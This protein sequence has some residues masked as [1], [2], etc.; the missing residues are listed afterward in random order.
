M[1]CQ[2]LHTRLQSFS[3]EP[4]GRSPINSTRTA[5]QTECESVHRQGASAIRGRLW[6]SYF[7]DATDSWE[8]EDVRTQND[9]EMERGGAEFSYQ[10]YPR[11]HIWSFH[12]GHTMTG[13]A[14]P[15][16]LGNPAN[17]DPEEAFAA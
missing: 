14:A 6:P 8:T 15:A 10:K 12:G 4:S 16:Y 3:L 7:P 9:I 13:T 2:L 5:L 17:V 1:E 11:D